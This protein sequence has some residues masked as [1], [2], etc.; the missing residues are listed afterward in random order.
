[1][2]DIRAHE[3]VASA[4]EE[5]DAPRVRQLLKAHIGAAIDFWNHIEGPKLVDVTSDGLEALRE[6]AKPAPETAE[7]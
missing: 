4:I 3:A 5:G 7:T 6:A 2:A 1:M